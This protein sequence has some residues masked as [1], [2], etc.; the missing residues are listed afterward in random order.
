MSTG[1]IWAGLKDRMKLRYVYPRRYPGCRIASVLPPSLAVGTG[2]IVMA[3][4]TVSPTLESLGRYA[5]VGEGA[6]ILD[7]RAVGNFSCI[8]QGARI[9]LP[10]HALDHVGTSHLF[11]SPAR[12]WVTED[13]LSPARKPPVELGADVLVSANAL[14]LSGVTL[15][16]GCVIGAGAVVREDVP[17]YAI[18]AGVPG[19]VVRYR[20]EADLRERLLASEWWER[21]DEELRAR[22]AHFRD[23]EAFLGEV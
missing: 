14:V 1:S 22:A 4:V 23:P 10:D 19:A 8:S 20:F 13:T 16:H 12:G 21:P 9:G 6:A 3:N 15:G 18:V 5:Y 7:C 17:P 2:A 11:S